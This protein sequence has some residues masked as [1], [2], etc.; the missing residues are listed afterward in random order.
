[1]IKFLDLQ[2]INNQYESEINSAMKSV[3]DSGWYIIGEKTK[4]FEQEFAEYCGTEHCIG[5]ANGLDALI[6][7]FVLEMIMD[8]ILQVIIAKKDNTTPKI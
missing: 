7:I 1:M 3:L 4:K 8:P 2:K 6:L 5:V